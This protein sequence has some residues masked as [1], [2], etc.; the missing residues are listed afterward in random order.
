MPKMLA[1]YEAFLIENSSTI[2]TIESSLR[3]LT[4]FLPGRF[5]DAELA[6]ESLSAT[7]NLLSLYH[8][9]LLARR[10]SQDPKLKP[11][12]PPSPHSRYTRAWSD[13]SGQY[14]WAARALEVI[15]FLQLVVEMSL[16][17]K[18]GRNAKWR[19]IVSIEFVKA[20]LRLILLRTSQRPVLSPAIPERD[21]DPA[22][23]PPALSTS[24]SP[25]LV[26]SPS[27]SPP[28]T[29][30]HLKNNHVPLDPVHP[31]LASPP[32]LKSAMPVEEYLL[33]KALNTASVKQPAFL[34]RPLTS[35]KDWLAE[36]LYILRPLFYV[37]SISRHGNSA[38]RPLITSLTI[39][40]LARSLRRT[41]P[42][43]SGLERSEYARRDRDL[44]WY[45]LR[46]PVWQFY[47]K[48]KL[49]SFADSTS[50]TPVLG[51]MSAFIRDWIPL[52]DSYHY[53][54]STFLLRLVLLNPHSVQT[55][56]LN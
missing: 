11:L 13:K 26:G 35:P 42:P 36:V 55:P 48:P 28:S 43:T 34:V 15:K 17:R 45:F 39:D 29:P 32:P 50:H 27:S 52:I 24:S 4:W 18:V 20:V 10:L 1:N 37:L 3:S 19:A 51:L 9:T 30:E 8:D 49:T 16:R 31:L 33:P 56:Q 54:G 38:V 5:K 47:T 40:L 21:L 12:I 44:L 41:P 6:S 2:A 25:T 46:G 22:T 23:L 7:L 14:K 53:C